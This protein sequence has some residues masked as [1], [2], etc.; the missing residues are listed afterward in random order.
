MILLLPDPVL[1]T[2]AKLSAGLITKLKSS[3]MKRVAVSEDFKKVKEEINK[4]SKRS[5]N[6]EIVIGEFL[7]DREDSSKDQ[8]EDE[9]KTYEE[10]KLARKERYLKR[11]DIQESIS[12][13]AE[14]ALLAV[15]NPATMNIGAKDAGKSASTRVNP[16]SN[17]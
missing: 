10:S 5:K 12:I 2:R 3:S 15:P 4:Y 13:A 9:G 7:K 14:L 8:K 16:K 11:G 17:N 1:P 6:G